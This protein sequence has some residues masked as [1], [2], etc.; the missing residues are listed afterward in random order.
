[1]SRTEKLC[2]AF[3]CRMILRLETSLPDVGLKNEKKRKNM[4]E[5][6]FLHEHSFFCFSLV[7]QIEYY[8]LLML[9]E[10][11][12]DEICQIRQKSKNMQLCC[13]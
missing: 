6:L 2:G 8:F 11:Y 1:M 5:D 9:I 3:E 10:I 12:M 13:H 7:C 4:K